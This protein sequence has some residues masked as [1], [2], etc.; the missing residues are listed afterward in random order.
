MFIITKMQVITRN[1]IAIESEQ[2]EMKGNG[3]S[4]RRNCY[5]CI[6]QSEYCAQLNM[7]LME[8]IES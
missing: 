6:E 3:R 5:F 4:K 1:F 7:T 2:D 8:F